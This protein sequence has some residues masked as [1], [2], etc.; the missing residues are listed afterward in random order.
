MKNILITAICLLLL[1]CNTSQENYEDTDQQINT[2][3]K[4]RIELDFNKSE[5]QIVKQL[6][7]TYPNITSEQ[8]AVWEKSGELEMKMINGKKKYFRN[9][10]SNLYRLNSEAGQKRDS[11]FGKR[12]SELSEFREEQANQVVS[13]IDN[14]NPLSERDW[15][16][17]FT[18]TVPPGTIP[19]GETIKCWMPYPKPHNSRLTDIQ[20]IRVNSEEYHISDPASPHRSLYM[21]KTASEKEETR[22][23]YELSFSTMGAWTDPDELTALPYN[24][25]SD[26]Y[27]NNTKEQLPHIVF[28]DEVKHLADSLTQGISDPVMIVEALYFWIEKSIPWASA[29]EYSIFECIPEYVLKYR[30]GDCGMVS[31]LFMSMARYKGIPVKW[32]SGWMIHPGYENLHDWTEVYYEGKGWI[33]LDMSFGLISSPDEK[34][35]DYYMTGIDAFR[36]IVNDA[37]SAKFDPPKEFYRS[38]PLDFQRGELEWSGGNLYFNK[39]HYSLEILNDYEK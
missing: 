3:R 8:M 23:I 36:M 32:Q 39:W 34:V 15:H 1:A 33:P 22:F 19:D 16:I 26:I 21:E 14:S 11:V 28:S 10:V 37:I 24:K 7:K 29:L 2:I 5:D 27:K 30:H 38:E 25:S 13:N 12:S 4:A 17:K 20:L 18:I 35:R 6:S 9:A 31:L